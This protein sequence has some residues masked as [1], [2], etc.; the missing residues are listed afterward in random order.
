MSLVTYSQML[1]PLYIYNF[2]YL[3]SLKNKKRFVFKF[4]ISFKYTGR[5]KRHVLSNTKKGIRSTMTLKLHNR[6][7]EEILTT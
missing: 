6:F 4:I 1:I 3:L 5:K 7:E 2:I